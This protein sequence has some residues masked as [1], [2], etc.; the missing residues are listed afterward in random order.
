MFRVKTYFSNGKFR[1]ETGRH[2]RM[3]LNIIVPAGEI[4]FVLFDDR[5][6]SPSCR[7]MRTSPCHL[8]KLSATDRAARSVDGTEESNGL[9]NAHVRA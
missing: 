4:N 3:L 6:E 7:E 2:T 9:S 5:K 1:V 8:E